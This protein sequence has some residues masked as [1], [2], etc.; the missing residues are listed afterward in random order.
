MVHPGQLIREVDHNRVIVMGP[1]KAY[2]FSYLGPLPFFDISWPNKL[3]AGSGKTVLWYV[4]PRVRD[5]ATLLCCQLAR[6]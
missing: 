3:V 4:P 1:W 5:F 2:V 6:L